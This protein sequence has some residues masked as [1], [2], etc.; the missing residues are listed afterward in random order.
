MIDQLLAIKQSA[1]LLRNTAGEAS[2]I[3]SIG[4]STGRVLPKTRVKYEKFLGGTEIAF[5]RAG[6][7]G[8]GNAVTFGALHAR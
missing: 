4:L 6:N 3:I 1:W 5:Y 2:L 8:I 7:G